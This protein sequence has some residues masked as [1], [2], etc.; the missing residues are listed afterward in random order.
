[1][2]KIHLQE[3]SLT[4]F[5]IQFAVRSS[6]HIKKKKFLSCETLYEDVKLAMVVAYPPQK[7]Q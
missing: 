6:T 2:S 3:D 4:S 7:N 1:M 5:V